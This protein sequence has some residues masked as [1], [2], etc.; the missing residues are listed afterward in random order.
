MW[1]SRDLDGTLSAAGTVGVG[2]CPATAQHKANASQIYRT[3]VS[4]YIE[5]SKIRETQH[6]PSG[7][8]GASAAAATAAP[9]TTGSSAVARV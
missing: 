3:M 4:E 9:A 1:H 2:S 6:I 7:T 8:T 5:I